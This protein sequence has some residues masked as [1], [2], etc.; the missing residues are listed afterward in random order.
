M[1][2]AMSFGVIGFMIIE[3]Y[4]FSDAV[5]M[6]VITISTVGFSEIHPL[7]DHGR[8]F[9]T[10]L[11]ITNVSVFFYSITTITA[12]LVDGEFQK[13]LKMYKVNKVIDKLENHVVVCGFGR[14]GV[15]VVEQLEVDEVPFIIIERDEDLIETVQERGYLCIEGDATNDDVLQSINLQKAKAIITTLPK[16]AD[17]VFVTLTAKEINPQIEIISRAS[18]DASETKLRRAGADHVIMPEKIGGEHM[19]KLVTK[20]DIM[21]FISLITGQE[22]I[23]GTRMTI[24]EFSF[25]HIE[26]DFGKKSIIELNIRNKTGANVIGIKDSNG[27]HVNPSSM[28]VIDKTSKL[29]VLGTEQ[30]IA[31]CKNLFSE[32][33]S[34]D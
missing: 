7:N 24:E 11:I 22:E 4:N 3:D 14:N 9:T 30:A 28:H 32:A 21:D 13:Y 10:I 1:F 20:P 19:A 2:A 27:F 29:I 6:T 17:N 8:I 33:P 25:E 5:Y 12:F 34:V 15:E 18:L 23:D 16:D 26:E 31:K